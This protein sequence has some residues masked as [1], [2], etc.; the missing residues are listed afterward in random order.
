[1]AFEPGIIANPATRQ[2]ITAKIVLRKGGGARIQ[3]RQAD[4]VSNDL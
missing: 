1:V 2:V 3:Y 4:R